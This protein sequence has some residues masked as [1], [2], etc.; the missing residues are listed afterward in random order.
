MQPIN[1]TTDWVT[2]K[3]VINGFDTN[4]PTMDYDWTF[5]GSLIPH[6]H[7]QLPDASLLHSPEALVNNPKYNI[8]LV[9][10]ELTLTIHKPGLLDFSFLILTH[11]CLSRTTMQA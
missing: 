3:C 7:D 1:A 9:D 2:L 11:F 10:G 5:N 4:L 8:S 6:T